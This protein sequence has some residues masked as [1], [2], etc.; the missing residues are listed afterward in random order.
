MGQ[1]G[2]NTERAVMPD[3]VLYFHADWTLRGEEKLMNRGRMHMAVALITAAAMFVSPVLAQAQATQSQNAETQ[4]QLPS[5][6][7]AQTVPAGPVP[8]RQVTLGTDYS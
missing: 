4:G 5:Q 1:G 6:P 8:A 7:Q 2:P 3:G